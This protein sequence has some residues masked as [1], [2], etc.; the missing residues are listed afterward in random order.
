[1]ILHIIRH[2]KSTPADDTT[3]DDQRTV[4]PGGRKQLNGTLKAYDEAGEMDPDVIFAAPEV[5]SQTGATMVASRFGLTPSDIIDAPALSP[6]GDAQAA[7]DQIRDWLK[8]QDDPDNAEVVAIG[9]NPALSNLFQLVHGLGTEE[10][11]SGSVK[12]KKG[13]VAKLKIY[14]PTGDNPTSEL[15]SYL[16]PGLARG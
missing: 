10:G 12:L 15:R 2:P 9:S 8:K 13:S 16:P 11:E 5:R 4:T 14:D 7:W 3:A 1:M 6:D